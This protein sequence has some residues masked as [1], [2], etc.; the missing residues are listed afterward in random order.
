MDLHF[1]LVRLDGGCD[2]SGPPK[3]ALPFASTP[4]VQFGLVSPSSFAL[5]LT[6]FISSKVCK[7]WDILVHGVVF[8]AEGQ[9]QTERETS[10]LRGLFKVRH[11]NTTAILDEFDAIL[12]VRILSSVSRLSHVP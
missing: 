12:V 4:S 8:T 11:R 3:T 2:N 6:L 7:L 10:N 1:N 9:S 5:N